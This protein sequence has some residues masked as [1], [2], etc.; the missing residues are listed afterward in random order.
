[1]IWQTGKKKLSAR[2]RSLDEMT[3]EVDRLQ[4][5][6]DDAQLQS[7]DVTTQLEKL[8]GERQKCEEDVR[9]TRRKMVEIETANVKLQAHRN[10]IISRSESLKASLDSLEV[11]YCG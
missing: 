7:E 8:Q 4:A 10:E 9:L 11:G 2:K 5:E 1:M 3:E 6:L